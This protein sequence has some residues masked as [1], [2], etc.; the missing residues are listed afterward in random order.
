MS[1]EESLATA[2]ENT[3]SCCYSWVRTSGGYEVGFP[4]DYS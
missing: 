2:M 3:V 4:A 1:N